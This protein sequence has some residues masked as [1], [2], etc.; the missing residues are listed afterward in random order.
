MTLMISRRPLPVGQVY[1]PKSGRRAC[2]YINANGVRH[3]TNAGGLNGER[4]RDH[5][6]E[7]MQPFYVIRQVT[8]AMY[9]QWWED[10]TGAP[11]S[12]RD[13]KSDVRPNNY[14]YEISMD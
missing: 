2:A 7:S 1:L 12:A 8:R 6:G 10:E 11:V 13:I 9:L 3:V 4:L 14:Y 5:R